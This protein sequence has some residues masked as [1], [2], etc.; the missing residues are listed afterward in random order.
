[1][2]PEEDSVTVWMRCEARCSGVESSE[3]TPP[4][5]RSERADGGEGV[6]RRASLVM[7][8]RQFES[9]IAIRE[10]SRS[11]RRCQHAEGSN[12]GDAGRHE[13][14]ASEFPKRVYTAATLAATSLQ[15]Q[16]DRGKAFKMA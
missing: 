13:D 5:S 4:D 1:M 14:P 3:M 9:R 6:S 11:K 10:R 15:D 12:Q 16:I 8:R 7:R 2:E